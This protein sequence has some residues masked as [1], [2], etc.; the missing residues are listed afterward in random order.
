M[1]NYSL[2]RR[3]SH[4]FLHVHLSNAFDINRSS[5]FI[6]MVISMRVVH[7]NCFLL[8]EVKIF[9]NVVYL[10]SISPAHALP[11]HRHNVL[12]H[13]LSSS[14]KPE[15]I[16]IVPVFKRANL[17]LDNPLFNLSEDSILFRTSV[18]H[19]ACLFYY[20]FLFLSPTEHL[21]LNN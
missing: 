7:S 19:K 16:V 6:S 12:Y 8:R 21:Y 1:L 14:A 18:S 3:R 2:F 5:L 9:D 15:D 10:F 11:Y 4:D 13:E 20:Y 17:S